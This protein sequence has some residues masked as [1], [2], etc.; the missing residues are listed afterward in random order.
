MAIDRQA[1]AARRTA[2]KTRQA[3][4]GRQ[5]IALGGGVDGN[6]LL[7]A[8]TG[9]ALVLL[10]AVLGVTILRVGQLLSVHMFVGMLLIPPVLLKLASTGY[11]FT[12]YYTLDPRYRSTGPPAPL[13]RAIAPVV[14]LS[15]VVVFASGIALL[16]VGPSAS[17]RGTL[18]SL[19]EASFVVWLIFTALHVI[20]HVAEIP[21][22]LGARWEGRLTGLAGELAESLPGMRR[23]AGADAPS[24]WNARGAARAGRLLSLSGV[25]L[26]GL[27]L[28]VFSISWYGPWLHSVASFVDR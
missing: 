6:R 16:V 3:I 1:S 22:A 28:A 24:E 18:M 20:G 23:V 4:A 10:L 7:T 21:R 11:R 5:A 27:A 12:R 26:A 25:L 8:Q 19:H 9:A 2:P 14:V 13:L 17:A 15:T